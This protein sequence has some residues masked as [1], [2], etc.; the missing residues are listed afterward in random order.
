L[1]TKGTF[2]HGWKVRSVT[3]REEKAISSPHLKAMIELAMHTGMR[4]GELLNLKW[5]HV[6]KKMVSS[7]SR[8][9]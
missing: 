5:S 7:D 4:R 3:K 1:L 6:D 8:L 2:I 9:K